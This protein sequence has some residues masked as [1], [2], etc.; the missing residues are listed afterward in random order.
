VLIG[1]L[2]LDFY[3]SI[4]KRKRKKSLRFLGFEAVMLGHCSSRRG[5]MRFSFI[6]L[7]FF[8]GGGVD[9]IHLH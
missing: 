7:L 1:I 2:E 6:Y 9:F 4:Q 3:L 5:A 8:G